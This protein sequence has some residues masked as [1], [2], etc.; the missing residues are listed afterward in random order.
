MQATIFHYF[1]GP[2]QLVMGSAYDMEDTY[3]D[4]FLKLP[5]SEKTNNNRLLAIYNLI[6]PVLAVIDLNTIHLK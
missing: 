1:S 3:I 2:P 6:L 5:I 4:K